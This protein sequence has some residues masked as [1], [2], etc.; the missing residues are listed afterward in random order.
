MECVYTMLYVGEIAENMN[1]KDLENSQPLRH[2]M[3][4]EHIGWR[5]AKESTGYYSKN[6]STH[7]QMRPKLLGYSAVIFWFDWRN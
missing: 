7:W 5:V 6:D 2:K 1:S 3:V 4:L